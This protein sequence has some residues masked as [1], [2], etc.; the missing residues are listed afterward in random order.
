MTTLTALTAEQTKR[1]NSD[2]ASTQRLIEKE[3][4]YMSHLQDQSRLVE[5]V[6]HLE[7]LNGMIINGWNAPVLD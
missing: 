3:L 7:K 6:S 4:V 1:V 2:I 5:L